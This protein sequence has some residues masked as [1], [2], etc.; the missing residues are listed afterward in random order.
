M[1]R[2]ER[3]SESAS[4]GKNDQV[5]HAYVSRFTFILPAAHVVSMSCEHLAPAHRTASIRREA[6][7]RAL[8]TAQTQTVGCLIH[9][10]SHGM[11]IMPNID[12]LGTAGARSD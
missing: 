11:R 8:E 7:P 3:A 12:A 10:V 5:F 4:S 2:F 9:A 1:L 6:P